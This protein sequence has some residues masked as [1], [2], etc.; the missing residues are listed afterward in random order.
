MPPF[1]I[2]DPKQKVQPAP[3][4]PLEFCLWLQQNFD[5]IVDEFNETKLDSYC[6]EANCGDAQ[7][8]S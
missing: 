7:R 6:R 4:I 1:L 8:S 2:K 3:P 5:N